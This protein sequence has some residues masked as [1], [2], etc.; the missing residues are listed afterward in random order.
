MTDTERLISSMLTYLG[1]LDINEEEWN[2]R[3]AFDMLSFIEESYRSSSPGDQ[4]RVD[5]AIGPF[6]DSPK[7]EAYARMLNVFTPIRPTLGEPRVPPLQVTAQE[8]I[9][10][11]E[12]AK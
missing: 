1:Q 9:S 8:L 6:T 12:Q 11:L 5:I 2:V 7:H 3:A 4:S 10:I